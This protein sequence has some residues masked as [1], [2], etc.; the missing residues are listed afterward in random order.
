MAIQQIKDLTPKLIQ[1]ANKYNLKYTHDMIT[2]GLLL[3][4]KYFKELVDDYG[5]ETFQI[6]IDGLEEHH[7]K[8]RMT[9]NNT[10]TFKVIMNN[11]KM[12]VNHPSY[13]K[14][15][16]GLRINIDTTN[17]DSVIPLLDYL[18]NINIIDKIVVSFSPIVDWGGNNASKDSLTNESFA[19]KEIDWKLELIKR[20][21]SV[22]SL[23]PERTGATCMVET[24]DAEVYDAFGNI[25]ACYE[26]PYTPA[27]ENSEYIEGVLGSKNKI[28]KDNP[29]R[30]W[31]KY[32]RNGIDN[33]CAS[34]KFYPVCG[35]GCPK[36]WI[37]EKKSSCPSFKYN[38]EDR[39]VLQY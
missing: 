31:S 39:L 8:R 20:N 19:N 18:Q 12:M 4:E 22:S 23:I 10:P 14:N 7:D 2:N 9:K 5:I 11:I 13:K 36:T 16:I 6:T 15:M 28:N 21:S 38:M 26:M 30:N 25:F 24:K 34:C 27:Y 17:Q 37:I 3:K 35:G 33:N 29:L 32:V 1:L